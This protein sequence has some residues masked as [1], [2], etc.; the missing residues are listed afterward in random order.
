[1]AL[2]NSKSKRPFAV[3]ISFLSLQARADA[4]HSSVMV[5]LSGVENP[6]VNPVDALL[7]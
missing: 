5:P 4:K 3:S 6:M 2:T 1:M 7:P